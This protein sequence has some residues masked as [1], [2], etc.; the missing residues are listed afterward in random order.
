MVVI[1]G[2]N[3]MNAFLSSMM[4]MKINNKKAKD[5]RQ[6]KENTNQKGT[7]T[8]EWGPDL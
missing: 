7:H 2:F 5:L 8:Q 4:L 6:L 1:I 3:S